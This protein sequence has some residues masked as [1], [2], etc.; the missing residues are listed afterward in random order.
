MA[1][2]A[3]GLGI[4]MRGAPK[5]YTNLISGAI[6]QK[7]KGDADNEDQYQSYLK[8]TTMDKTK[9]HKI[10]RPHV[11]EL[12][13]DFIK[14]LVDLKTSNPRGW[15]R[16]APSMFNDFRGQLADLE[17]RSKRYSTFEDSY[18]NP[19]LK[20]YR[21]GQVDKA[22]TV[23]QGVNDYRKLSETFKNNG[24]DSSDDFAYDETG[25]ISPSK[26]YGTFNFGKQASSFRRNALINT[27]R[28]LSQN[29]DFV[30]KGKTK[31]LFLTNA[32]ADKYALEQKLSGTDRNSIATVEDNYHAVMM[33]EAA[34]YQLQD[35][36]SRKYNTPPQND[37]QLFKFYTEMVAPEVSGSYSQTFGN[38][39]KGVSVTT[40]IGD[41][42]GNIF[43]TPGDFTI[44]PVGKTVTVK[45]SYLTKGITFKVTKGVI[46]DGMVNAQT[47]A[48]YTK[49]EAD[50]LRENILT[51]DGADGE[52]TQI[53]RYNNKNYAVVKFPSGL[54]QTKEVFMPINAVSGVLSK[55]V[56]SKA[57]K[58][59]FDRLV[60]N[61][62]LDGE[63]P[64]ATTGSTGKGKKKIEGFN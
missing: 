60:K 26:P 62:A 6:Q 3:L 61:L 33:D 55:M 14:K 35:K 21:P 30:Q 20:L 64:A 56:T 51:P 38:K 18:S 53:L 40:N 8:S 12:T 16:E 31:T 1:L 2:D 7:A 19:N 48:V 36:Y 23:F 22:I 9:Y 11:N 13:Q 49:G 58:A 27:E 44:G 29:K 47:L 37:D 41:E 17:D 57:D 63:G 15:Q 59:Y 34:S 54:G 50:V 46:A 25:S 42:Q 5:E 28:V 4:G 32:E 24:I 39:P 10:V 43:T 52:I 45:S